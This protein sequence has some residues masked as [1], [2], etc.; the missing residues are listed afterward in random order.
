MSEES[1]LDRNV[2]GMSP[3]LMKSWL[4][5]SIV[6]GKTII[7]LGAVNTKVLWNHIHALSHIFSN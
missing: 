5:S 2:I 4:A 1:K 3:Y 6:V 7:Y